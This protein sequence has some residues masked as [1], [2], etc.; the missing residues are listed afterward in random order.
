MP[1]RLGILGMWHVHTPGL[2]S[3]IAQYPK[4]FQL[5]GGFD[6]E[7]DVVLTRQAA[8]KTLLPQF[9][10]HASPEAV[11]REELDG[12]IVEGRVSENLKWA[13][14][15]IDSGRPVL[16]EKPAGDSFRP[17]EAL[18]EAPACADDLSV[19]VH[20]GRAGVAVPGAARGTRPDLRAARPSP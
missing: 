19:S 15:A 3:Q 1:I 16:L 6:P 13:Q 10:W 18:P 12:V 17:F 9:V 2:V 4:E 14:M 20:V 8:W 11:L 7:P 5:V